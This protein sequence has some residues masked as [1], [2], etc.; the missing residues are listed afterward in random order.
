[1]NPTKKHELEELSWDELLKLAEEARKELDALTWLLELMER[2]EKEIE[3]E[4]GEACA[5]QMPASAIAASAKVRGAISARIRASARTKRRV[6]AKLEVIAR[7]KA[8]S[9]RKKSKKPAKLKISTTEIYEG[10]RKAAGK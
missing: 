6:P 10:R 1:M 7:L 2:I 9:A 8:E 4:Y 5:R 3:E